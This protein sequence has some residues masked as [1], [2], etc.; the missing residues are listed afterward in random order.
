M[1]EDKRTIFIPIGPSE[2]G[3]VM[4]TLFFCFLDINYFGSGI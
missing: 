3:I 1:A 4:L 2:L